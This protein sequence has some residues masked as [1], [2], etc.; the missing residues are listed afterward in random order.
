M[1]C[2]KELKQQYLPFL[3]KKNNRAHIKIMKDDIRN[4]KNLKRIYMTISSE[5]W[6]LQL[7]GKMLTAKF[8]KNILE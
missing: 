7:V 5:N 1:D 4:N 8:G 2:H 3:K 6:I